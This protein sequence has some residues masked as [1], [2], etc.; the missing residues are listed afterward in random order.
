MRTVLT[1]GKY[2]LTLLLGAALGVLIFYE[3]INFVRDNEPFSYRL[4]YDL[5][6]ITYNRYVDKLD[7]FSFLLSTDYDLDAATESAKMFGKDYL[8]G[9]KAKDDPRIGCEV[10]KRDS[11]LDLSRDEDV[12]TRDLAASPRAN[13]AKFISSG[14]VTLNSGL[15][16][17]QYNF[18]FIDPLGAV[19]AI[20]QVSVPK[21]NKT[22]LL[23]CGAGQA[24]FDKFAPDFAVFFNSFKF[25]K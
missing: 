4:N 1:F 11:S 13:K 23:L 12:L 15:P 7:K 18:N 9:F 22:Y 19:T 17:F 2:F 16:A 5:R 21:E 20:N 10:R 6:K 14:K 8:V 24:Y 3:L 25:E